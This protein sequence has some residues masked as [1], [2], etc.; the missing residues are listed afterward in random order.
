MPDCEPPA[1]WKTCENA[2]RKNAN[3]YK[4]FEVSLPI[5]FSDMQNQELMMQFKDEFLGNNPMTM[6]YHA[7]S[8]N[9][10]PHMHLMFSMR[11]NDGLKRNSLEQFFKRANKKNPE[12]GGAPKVDNWRGKDFML[13]ARQRWETM[14][15]EALAKADVQQEVSC[16]TLAEQGVDR[17]PEPKIGYAAQQIEQRAPGTSTRIKRFDEVMEFNQNQAIEVRQKAKVMDMIA[18]RPIARRVLNQMNEAHRLM[19]LSKEPVSLPEPTFLEVGRYIQAKEIKEPARE[20]Y[21][22]ADRRLSTQMSKL[23]CLPWYEFYKAPQMLITAHQMQKRVDSLHGE[24]KAEYASIETRVEA[25][26]KA[27]VRDYEEMLGFKEESKTRLKTKAL[28]LVDELKSECGLG[29][30]DLAAVSSAE[31]STQGLEA[32]ERQA[33]ADVVE[34]ERKRLFDIQYEKDRPE[35]ERKAK[36][37]AEAER[38]RQIEWANRPRPQE[39]SGPSMGM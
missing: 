38:Q 35:R 7:G 33:A 32:D 30:K 27:R 28:K 25:I 23:E 16:K 34:A 10:N 13:D 18:N 4:E 15:N 1:F 19:G 9:D 8:N 17:L 26:N 22:D 2:E 3:L 37:E 21:R 6:A 36:I 11:E 39:P 24:H 31:Q 20:A 5:E 29:Y 12:L 14:L